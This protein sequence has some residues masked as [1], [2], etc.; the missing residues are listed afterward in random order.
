MN[1][2]E[3]LIPLAPADQHL[4]GGRLAG[5]GE[6]EQA[7]E[8]GSWGVATVEADMLRFLDDMLSNDILVDA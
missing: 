5:E 2:P 6:A 8:G 7:G 4:V 1:L 3:S